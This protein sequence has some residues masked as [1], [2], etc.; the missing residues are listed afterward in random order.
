MQAY[1]IAIFIPFQ[2]NLK[3]NK[4]SS[5]EIMFRNQKKFKQIT[6]IFAAV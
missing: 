5:D 1:D 4:I 6:D 3:D 2:T